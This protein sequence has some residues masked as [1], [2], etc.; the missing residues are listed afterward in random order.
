MQTVIQNIIEGLPLPV[1]FTLV[2]VFMY[3]LG[4]G[5]DILVDEAISLSVKWN[6]PKSP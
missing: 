1:L 2:G 3:M 6:V 4:K 5:A